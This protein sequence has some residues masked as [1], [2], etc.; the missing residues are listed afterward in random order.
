MQPAVMAGVGRKDQG[1]GTCQKDT[2]PESARLTLR[3]CEYGMPSLA[4]GSSML[5][6]ASH[7]LEI[8]TA[9]PRPSGKRQI[10]SGG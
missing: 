4:M 2:V 8:E 10:G 3:W 6:S 1:S 5:K 9:A 7:I